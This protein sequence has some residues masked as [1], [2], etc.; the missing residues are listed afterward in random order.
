MIGD[1]LRTLGKG[2]YTP[3][4]L[5][6]SIGGRRIWV[7]RTDHVANFQNSKSLGPFY[8]T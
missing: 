3:A 5:D 1:S 4:E 8:S 6:G 7:T 2:Y